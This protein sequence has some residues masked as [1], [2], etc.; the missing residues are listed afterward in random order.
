MPAPSAASGTFAGFSTG[1]TF[2][3]P[4]SPSDALAGSTRITTRAIPSEPDSGLLSVEANVLLHVLYVG[5]R[6]GEEGWLYV[7]RKDTS[8][9]GWLPALA[10]RHEQPDTP[11]EGSFAAPAKGDKQD[12]APLTCAP[13]KEQPRCEQLD[14]T[15][16]PWASDVP[17][18][19]HPE[20]P[21]GPFD[22]VGHSADFLKGFLRQHLPKALGEE[23][24]DKVVRLFG[25]PYH[26]RCREIVQFL[27]DYGVNDEANVLMSRR[28]DGSFSGEAFAV[29]P[30]PEQASLAIEKLDREYM[31]KRYINVKAAAPA[32]WNKVRVAF[33]SDDQAALAVRVKAFQKWETPLGRTDWQKYCKSQG[34]G[35][36]SAKFPSAGTGG[37]DS[38]DGWSQW[39][40]SAVR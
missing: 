21:A 8:E 23:D 13:A 26:A 39:R 27:A 4:S 35:Q 9:E 14:P 1:S 24:D 36:R 7:Q 25:V 6:P 17:V 22:P 12:A 28:D 11:E 40:T 20:K 31:G 33:E 30:S 16:S 18:T 32:D 34:V 3:T 38:N 5:A 15:R 10:I 19:S 29:F 2:P 37:S